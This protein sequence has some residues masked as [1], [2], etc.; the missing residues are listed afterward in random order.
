MPT[1]TAVFLSGSGRTLQNLLDRTA[2]RTLPLDLRL[3][4][5]N[6]HDAYG[7]RRAERAGVPTLHLPTAPPE[8][9]SRAAFDRVRAAG[10]DLVLL[11]GFLRRLILPSDFAGRVLNIH[12][13]LLPEFGGR[14]CY[15]DRVHRAVLAAGRTTTGCTVHLVT[16]DYDQGPILLQR[17]VPV[18]PTDTVATLR[19]RVFQAERQAYPDAIRAW[20]HHHAP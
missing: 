8:E 20:C 14:G 17:Q 9:W 3:V 19:E 13:S 1:P 4:V 6:R 10:C 2:D 12:P 18:L 15:G 16:D 5:S 7:L 11:A